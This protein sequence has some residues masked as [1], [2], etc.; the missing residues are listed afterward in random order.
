M[1]LTLTPCP[2]PTGLGSLTEP[3]QPGV[4]PHLRLYPPTPT[5]VLCPMAALCTFGGL[6]PDMQPQTGRDGDA[7]C[8][9]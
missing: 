4:W 8:G 1:P 5:W 7:G 2:D 6:S 3:T 9:Q